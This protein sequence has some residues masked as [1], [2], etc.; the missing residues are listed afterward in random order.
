MFLTFQM[1]LYKITSFNRDELQHVTN[2]AQ[3]GTHL[4]SHLN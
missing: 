2:F 1:F 4:I 3:V